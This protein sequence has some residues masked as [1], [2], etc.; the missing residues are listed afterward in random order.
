[1]RILRTAILACV[2]VGASAAVALASPL[3]ADYPGP[4]CNVCDFAGPPIDAL[5]HGHVGAFFHTQ[6]VMGSVSLL[7]RAPFVALAHSFGGGQLVE[8]RI[9]ALACLLVAA[10]FALAYSRAM[11]RKGHPFFAQLAVVAL[12]VAGPVTSAAL[13]WGHPEEVLAASLCVAGAVIA[14][15]GRAVAGGVLLGLAL[16]TKDW[17]WLAVLPV[18][19]TM[20][21]A[22]V[23]MLL[24]TGGTAALFTLPM[25]VGDAGR[26]IAQIQHY[27][28]PGNGL[29]PANIWWIYGRQGGIDL[30]ATGS[31]GAPS[32]MLPAW[33]G[34]I[35][36]LLVIAVV[37]GLSLAWWRVRRGR[38]SHDVIQLLAL[39]FLARCLLDPLTYSYHH[40]PFVFALVAYGGL[41]RRGLPWV[42]AFSSLGIWVLAKWIAPIGDPTLFNRVYLAWMLPVAAYLAVSVFAPGRLPFRP[43][44]RAL[45]ATAPR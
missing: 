33:L 37:L 12:V 27:G 38:D 4:P 21:H 11:A 31:R 18:V 19:V 3:G 15:R 6:P 13:R 20:S 10:A 5:V 23:R 16:A 34:H 28:M 9:G 25:L 30:S 41:R 29:T 1:M 35:S 24:V 44:S 17:A 7:L 42:A 2:A 22:R 32:Y 14:V 8:Y 45:P 43:A 36:H 26:F 40:L 39:V